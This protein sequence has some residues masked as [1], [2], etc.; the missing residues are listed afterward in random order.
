MLKNT[1]LDISIKPRVLIAD[2]SRIVRAT[3][4]KHIEGLFEFREALDGEQA[5][6]VL[7]LDPNIRVVIT[8][9]TMPKLDGYGL[10]QRIRASK[11]SRIRNVP[12]V[13][14]SGSDEQEERDRAKA[15]GATD[16]IT[17]GIGTAQL[18]SRLDVLSKLVATQDEIERN[19]EALFQNTQGGLTFALPS[20][21][22]LKEQ[23]GVMLEN[24]ILHGKN[25]VILNACVALRRGDLTQLAAPP[26]SVINAIG[27]LLQRT[28]R[29]SDCVAK[30]G[31]AEFTLATG[32]IQFES[33]RNF[34]QR[35]C[36]AIANAKLVTGDSMPIVASCGMVSLSEFAADGDVAALNLTA[37]RTIAQR[38]AVLGIDH[39]VSGVV[40]PEEEAA[41]LRGPTSVEPDIVPAALPTEVRAAA[42]DIVT[43]LRWMKEGR[44]DKVLM[45]MGELSAELKPLVDLMMQREK[46]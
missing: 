29:Q 24:A 19:L 45:H 25:F 28:V 34:A 14:V 1:S 31:D 3:L 13:V 17:K 20:L 43:M 6:E 38:R 46:H 37:L 42:P 30:T 8:D 15:A 12:V 21:A 4:I 11:I 27:E 32:N 5:W 7:L 22:M 44:E 23:A 40:G 33:A 9:L 18:L 16:L 41:F 26:P 36:A 2:D 39:A 35:V 10:L